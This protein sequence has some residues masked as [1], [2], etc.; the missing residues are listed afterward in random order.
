MTEEYDPETWARKEETRKLRELRGLV[1][2]I[3]R[4]IVRGEISEKE[5]RDLMDRARLEA[6]Y[7]IPGQLDLYDMIYGSRFERL[8]EQFI[9]GGKED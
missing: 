9:R 1:D 5:A 7:K 8:I 4:K 3:C 6:S 2:P